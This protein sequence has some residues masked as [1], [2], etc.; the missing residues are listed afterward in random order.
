MPPQT[1]EVHV[2]DGI[3]GG[4]DFLLEFQGL[5]LSVTCPPG[6][7]PG[8][9]IQIEV[10]VPATADA[11]EQVEV[12]VPAG[13]FPG[14]EFSVDFGGTTF[15]VMVPDGCEPG[16]EILVNV[17]NAVPERAADAEESAAEERRTAQVDKDAELARQMQQPE[18]DDAQWACHVC[19]LLN[20]A[21]LTCCAVCETDRPGVA[22]GGADD[23]VE[24]ARQEELD[25]ELAKRL[26]GDEVRDSANRGALSGQLSGG[27]ATFGGGWSS[28][29]GPSSSSVSQPTN[30]SLFSMPVGT[31]DGTFGQPAG[32]FHV[33]QL[34]QV[35]R[36]D[37]SWTYGKILSHE[38]GGGTYSVMTRAGAKHFVERADIT[39]DVVI[40]PGDGGCAQ[41]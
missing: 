4:D 27:G 25:A 6:C 7:G 13:C 5:Q 32:D 30:P 41:Q 22:R 33:G 39:D 16:S 38:E 8:D 21:S 1:V 31:S 2:P 29:A 26:Q 18:A 34:V 37:G 9:A 35:T 24:R 19:T 17:P 14:M 20:D 15:E 40:N 12:T 36:S 11:L 23:P 28:E 10:D 3:I